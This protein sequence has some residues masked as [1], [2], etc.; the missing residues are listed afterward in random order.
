ML[1]EAKHE[2]ISRKLD[3]IIKILAGI[4]L[5]DLALGDKIKVLKE[6]GFG[7]KE[8]AEL[9]GTTPATVTTY[10]YHQKKKEKK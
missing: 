9:S 2:D 10:L 7:R 1:N 8:I 3:I 5:R 6:L 4:M